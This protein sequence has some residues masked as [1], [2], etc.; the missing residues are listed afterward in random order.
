[1]KNHELKPD[2][3]AYTVPQPDLVGPLSG[4]LFFVNPEFQGNV[5]PDE[6]KAAMAHEMF[7]CFQDDLLRQHGR[8]YDGMPDWIIEGEAAWAGEVATRPTAMGRGFW[9]GWLKDTTNPLFNRTYD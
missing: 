6:L 1:N 5:D 2:T 8:D 7:H 3:L 9:A 4:C